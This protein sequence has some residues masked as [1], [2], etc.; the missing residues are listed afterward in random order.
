MVAAPPRQRPHRWAKKTRKPAKAVMANAAQMDEKVAAR[1]AVKAPAKTVGKVVVTAA[2]VAAAVSAAKVPKVKSVHRVRADAEVKAAQK[3]GLRA[4]T[5]CVKAKP[6][7][8]AVS[9][10]SVANAQ[11]ALPASVLHAKAVAMAGETTATKDATKHSPS[12][13]LMSPK[14]ATNAHPVVKAAM[15]VV[16]SVANAVL[17]VVVSVVNAVPN[18]V[19]AMPPR[20]TTTRLK[21]G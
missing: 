14:C 13:P 1:V 7:L 11:S 2:V 18:A 10:L 4:A 3:G 5:S 21:R 9:A 17:R 16:V 6:D 12:W 15:R 19:R 20:V 8:H